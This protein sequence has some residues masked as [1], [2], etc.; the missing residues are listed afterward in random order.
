MN[1]NRPEN[2]QPHSSEKPKPLKLPK[3]PGNNTPTRNSAE[4]TPSPPPTTVIIGD[5]I[6]KRVEGQKLGR[7]V[8]HRE[9]NYKHLSH[10][11]LGGSS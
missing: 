5:S 9:H 8:K 2:L 7:R 11:T 10:L 4:V 3:D 1:L 6:R